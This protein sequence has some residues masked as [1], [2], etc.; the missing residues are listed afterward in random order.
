MDCML[1]IKMLGQFDVLQDGTRLNIPTRHAQALFAY[2][3]LNAGIVQR[4]ERLAGLLW[5]DSSDDSS[6][7]TCATS[8]GGCVK[9]A[10]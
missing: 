1:D 9:P 5:P 8:C 3:I 6:A 2:L 4:R 7:A 10:V